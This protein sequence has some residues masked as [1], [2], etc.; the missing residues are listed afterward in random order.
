M[1]DF[2]NELKIKLQLHVLDPLIFGVQ[3]SPQCLDWLSKRAL[4]AWF[5]FGPGHK[6]F[7]IGLSHLISGV[8]TVAAVAAL[9]AR[10][11]RP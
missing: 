8:G 1:L 4:N 3:R 9:A 5:D 6:C 10:L 11:F 2:F 7:N